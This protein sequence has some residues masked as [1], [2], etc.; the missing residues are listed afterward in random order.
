MQLYKKNK[1]IYKNLEKI[2]SCYDVINKEKQSTVK[3]YIIRLFNLIFSLVFW[4]SST[5]F[6]FA[7]ENTIVSTAPSITEII[8]ALGAENQLLAVSTECDYPKDAIKKDK[9]GNSYFFNKEKLLK[10]SP[11][12]LLTVEGAQYNNLYLGKNSKIKTVIY[13][14]N[15]V[16][17]IYSAILSIGKITEKEKKAIYII[18]QI[19][20][21]IE[22]IKPEKQ[23]RILYLVQVEPIITIGSKS[24]ISDI[25]RKSGQ[26]NVTDKLNSF[27]PT[28]SCEYLISLQPDVI[29]ISEKTNCKN[30]E[31]LFPK[32][33]FIFLSKEQNSL[34][35]RPG[36]RIAEAVKFFTNI[37]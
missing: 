26:I 7:Q 11:N 28:V 8:Y 16:N 4:L 34:I 19:K 9:I 31:K 15:S 36:P 33:K 23:Q 30:L 2:V 27:Y 12:Y 29:V 14:I 1:R 17:S 13:N 35:S 18:N 25:I 21:E 32:T 3:S 10:L 24:Y 20:S 5:S 6:V 22:N 37:K